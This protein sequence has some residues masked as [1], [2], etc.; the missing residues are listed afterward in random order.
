MRPR[1]FIFLL[2]VFT[3]LSADQTINPNAPCEAIL[4]NGDDALQVTFTKKS[5]TQGTLSI[6]YDTDMLPVWN[7]TYRV[8]DINFDGLEDIAVV[9]SLGYGGVNVYYSV[10][11]AHRNTYS[12]EPDLYL[13]NYVLHP[14]QKVV[15]SEY[16]SGPRHYTELYKVTEGKLQSYV[17]YE[18][19]NPDRD[20][21]YVDSLYGKKEK[22]SGW[23]KRLYSCKAFL[24]RQQ[25]QSLYAKVIKPRAIL[26]HDDRGRERS[27]MYLIQDDF[28]E[29]LRGD[30]TGETVLIRFNGKKR[31]EKY[32]KLEDLQILDTKIYVNPHKVSWYDDGIRQEEEAQDELSLTH[33]SGNRYFFEIQTVGPNIHT[34]DISG[35][36]QENRGKLVYREKECVLT[37]HPTKQGF[38]L[39]DK[40]NECRVGSCGARAFFDGL[41]FVEE[42]K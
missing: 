20:L 10:Y 17:V 9:N 42:G 13:S 27:G 40:E 32:L 26:Y 24:Y 28:V 2:L 30:P 25:A 11:F 18:N 22:L 21:C 41:K 34:C 19:Y 5:N 35:I 6:P 31:V 37:L 7:R 39:K 23:E 1:Y 29:I 3:T 36:A 4:L 38:M 33:I 14:K 16:K 12:A 15:E 8:D